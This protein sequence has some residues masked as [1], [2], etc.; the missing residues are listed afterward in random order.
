MNRYVLLL[1]VLIPL[2][3]AIIL[4]LVRRIWNHAVETLVFLVVML[5]FLTA[6]WLV[7]N[8]SNTTLLA[9]RVRLAWDGLAAAFLLI[10]SGTL[11]VVFLFS[12]DLVARRGTRLSYYP[13]LMFMVA[14]MTGVLVAADLF[15]L[16]LFVEL[17][18]VSSFFIIALGSNPAAE[19]GA[20]KFA[21]SHIVGS[22]L[23]VIG[24]AVLYSIA[25]GLD[26][27][28]LARFFSSDGHPY[29]NTVAAV[30]LIAGLSLK[31]GFFPFHANYADG[32]VSAS[33]PAAVLIS[34]VLPKITG[35]YVFLRLFVNVV[36]APLAGMS[37]TAV[38]LLSFFMG[39]VLASMPS[40]SA[41]R[42]LALS[43]MA[44][45]GFVLAAVGV[46]AVSMQSPA[47]GETA[48]RLLATGILFHIFSHVA[49]GTALY[50]SAGSAAYVFETRSDALLNGFGN[51]VPT[52]GIAAATGT[53][54]LIGVP[55]L[56]GFWSRLLVIA[57][58]FLSGRPALG[59]LFLAGILPVLLSSSRIYRDILWS[60]PPDNPLP[61][62][63]LPTSMGLPMLL[64]A[65]CLFL[66]G[67]AWV[68]FLNAVF[69]PAAHVLLQGCGYYGLLP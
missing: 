56:A 64:L 68:F 60:P 40:V 34:V 62:S 24:I 7:S 3:T 15:T 61:A 8:T 5:S 2:F 36:S 28:R 26:M 42:R 30:F 65:L 57:G 63:P 11:L 32:A 12:I 29:A 50:M 58:V 69:Q 10:L 45:N 22:A 18:S 35:I 39:Y 48:L 37:M 59:L 25:G 44:E 16:Y 52:A 67:I 4:P 55:P 53:F 41:R 23:V 6:V 20:F 1:L 49:A 43:S 51:A 54:S 66:A 14:G 33:T 31:S 19:E 13:L 17:A 38:G 21:L 47:S 27:A 46:L 9:G